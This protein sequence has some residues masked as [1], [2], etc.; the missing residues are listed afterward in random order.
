MAN[1]PGLLTALCLCMMNDGYEDQQ[2]SAT[3]A[4]RNLSDEPANAIPFTNAKDCLLSLIKV[5]NMDRMM[6]LT[7]KRNKAKRTLSTKEEMMQF[8][9][10]D[11][12][13]TISF[14]MKT[15]ADTNRKR[16][17]KA[18]DK[19]KM[20]VDSVCGPLKVTGWEQWQ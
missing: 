8:Y 15:V 7:S 19:E 16:M 13:A 3:S 10:C 17:P 2:L 12:I 1:V 4:L 9:A 14:W 11:A 5:A 18:K 20:N 6:A